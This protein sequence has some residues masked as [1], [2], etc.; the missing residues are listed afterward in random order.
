MYVELGSD[1]L[2]FGFTKRDGH[3]GK[4]CVASRWDSSDAPGKKEAPVPDRC[5]TLDDFFHLHEP[6]CRV[7]LHLS[8]DGRLLSLTIRSGGRGALGPDQSFTPEGVPEEMVGSRV[9]V[10]DTTTGQVQY[11]FGLD[12]TS[13]GGVWSPDGRLLAAYVQDSGPPCPAVWSRADGT[14]SHYRAAHVRPFFGF[15]VIRWTPDSAA[16]I[17]KLRASATAGDQTRTGE[18]GPGAAV[19]VYA[20]DPH[21]APTDESAAALPGSADDYICDLGWIDVATGDVRVL[22][23]D[24][25]L[26]GWEV[27]PDGRSLVVLRY[28]EAVERLQQFYADL[29][30]VPLDGSEAV[31]VA[32]RIPQRYPI[33]FAWSPDSQRIAYTTEER[34]QRQGV[35]VVAADGSAAPL[36]L[37]APDEDMELS[38]EEAPH[39]SADGRTILCPAQAGHWEIAVDATSRRRVRPDVGREV[40]RWVQ[41]PRTATRWGPTDDAYLYVVRN[42]ATKDEGLASVVAENGNGDLLFELP[43]RQANYLYGMEVA[44]D[45]TLYLL[46]EGGDHPPELWRVAGRE[47]RRLLSLNPHLEGVALGHSHLIEYR[48]LDGRELRAA[49]FLPP[50]WREGERAPVVV[51]VYGD[52]LGSEVL[53]RFNGSDGMLHPQLLAAGGYAVVYPDM[54]MVDRD[55]LRQLPGLVL[56]AVNRLVDLEMAD[57]ERVGVMGRSYGGYCTLSLLVQTDRFRAAVSHAG[58]YDL[59]GAYVAMAPNGSSMWLGWAESGQGRMGGSLWERR[60]VYIENSPLYYLDR[61]RTPVLLT[62]GSEDGV[63]PA[64]AE[65]AYTALKRLGKRVELRKYLGEGHWTGAWSEPAYRDLAERVRLWFDEHLGR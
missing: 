35:Y 21:A 6:T 48:A 56:P 1:M 16:L 64:Q 40:L 4:C 51:E 59:I 14:C 33:C 63:P 34:G 3:R 55:P 26:T 47:P 52:D 46:L 5:F 37:S 53:H 45:G 25:R 24:W 41:R 38:G 58:F 9:L 7:P 15:E 62:C 49:V 31:V 39:W 10:V 23:R 8:I 27:A 29:T 65:G 43:K 12:A 28:T 42:A 54:P 32:R 30:V 61:V 57:P 44:P 20:F 2:C 22:A 60:E 13:W 36:N 11:P 50:G 18:Q 17:T 19:R